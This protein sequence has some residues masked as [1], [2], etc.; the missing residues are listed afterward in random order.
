M[1]LL[2]YVGKQ[3]ELVWNGCGLLLTLILGECSYRLVEA[4][5]RQLFQFKVK[6]PG[7]SLVMLMLGVAAVGRVIYVSDGVPG[8]IRSKNSDEKALF[9]QHYVDLH[10]RGLINAYR[11]ECDFYD[12]R[13]RRER[14]AASCTP[15]SAVGG[16]LLWGDS[17]AQ[18]LSLGLRQIPSVKGAF[19]Q[20]ATSGCR[21]SLGGQRRKMEVDNNCDESN[22]FALAEIKRLRPAVVVLAQEIDH[23][24]TDWLSIANRLHGLGVQRV[25]LFG[26]VPRWRPSLPVVIA[27]HYWDAPASYA[28]YGLDPVVFSTDRLLKKRYENSDQLEYVSAV[29]GL[30]RIEGCLARLPNNG[31]LMAVDYGHLSPTGST[32]VV[33]QLLT[34]VVE[35]SLGKVN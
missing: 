18:A 32:Y 10:Q 16:L 26:P 3:G 8:S 27:N 14:I 23:E 2:H 13:A 20:V 24:H 33:A 12:G 5:S 4:P 34:P 17:H 25:I 19:A 31:E 35:R 21:P 9:V 28:K 11:M 1:V 22:R 29:D 6:W 15:A 30:C 7:L